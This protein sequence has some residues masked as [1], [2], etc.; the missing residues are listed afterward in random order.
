MSRGIIIPQI[1]R[2]KPAYLREASYPRSLP[3]LAAVVSA[4]AEGIEITFSLV[5]ARQ[6]STANTHNTVSTVS[7]VSVAR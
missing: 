1:G 5:K 4:D 6:V 7:M 3:R 2:V